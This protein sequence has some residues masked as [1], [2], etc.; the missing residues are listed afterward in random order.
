MSRSIH[1][2]TH[3][4]S[5]SPRISSTVN[6]M[7]SEN[8]FQIGAKYKV[9]QCKNMSWAVIRMNATISSW[10][11]W[12][13]P[14]APVCG[15]ISISTA[16]IHHR[17]KCHTISYF[18]PVVRLLVPTI[19]LKM[20][21]TE[22]FDFVVRFFSRRIHSSFRQTASNQMGKASVAN[23]CLFDCVYVS[24]RSRYTRFVIIIIVVAVFL[25]HS[26]SFEPNRTQPIAFRRYTLISF[27]LFI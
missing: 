20:W 10:R 7:R 16:S 13:W 4:V 15:S 3:S 25:S 9:G 19:K 17:L 27:S 22:S 11:L 18:A 23:I 6:S 2:H 5:C 14:A 1:T 24:N 12:L 26:L 21:K 8:V